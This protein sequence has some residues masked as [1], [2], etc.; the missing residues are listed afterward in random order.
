[1]NQTKLKK[2]VLA[3]IKTNDALIL[4]IAKNSCVSFTT[5][6]FNWLYKNQKNLTMYS[7]LQLICKSF[8]CTIED[9]LIL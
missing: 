8:N 4:A 9:L 7:N 1:M 6:K 3:K 5:V 2:E